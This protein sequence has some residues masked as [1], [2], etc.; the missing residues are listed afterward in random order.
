MM[1]ICI[2]FLGMIY[3]YRV[4]YNNKSALKFTNSIMRGETNQIYL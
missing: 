3:Q 2:L 4:L 1:M